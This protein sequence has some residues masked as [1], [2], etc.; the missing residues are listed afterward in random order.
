MP[1]VRYESSTFVTTIHAER[2][3]DPYIVEAQSMS[4]ATYRSV[5]AKPALLNLSDPLSC[6]RAVPLLYLWLS[7]MQFLNFLPSVLTI[8]TYKGLGE[9]DSYW[10]YLPVPASW[11][12]QSTNPSIHMGPCHD[13]V[14]P[15]NRVA[16][17]VLLQ[18]LFVCQRLQD[19]YDTGSGLYNTVALWRLSLILGTVNYSGPT[20]HYSPVHDA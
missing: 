5:I 11:G 16:S 8:R 4:A 17:I 20:T 2:S 14:I 13:H 9:S 15:Q 18:R 10:H 12:Y 6:A 3:R 7:N 19:S 1:G